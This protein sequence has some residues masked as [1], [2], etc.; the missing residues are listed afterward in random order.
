MKN[1]AKGGASKKEKRGDQHRFK[2][3][4]GKR[5]HNREEGEE[6]DREAEEAN[7]ERAELYKQAEDK[8]FEAFSSSSE[9]EPSDQEA[10]GEEEEQVS[11]NE[12]SPE[13]QIEGE[14]FG[15]LLKDLRLYD[16]RL[17]KLRLL[18]SSPS[19][20]ERGKEFVQEYHNLA[21]VYC[22]Y[23]MFYMQLASQK[24][25][26]VHPILRILSNLRPKVKEMDKEYARH[27]TE[28]TNLIEEVENRDL[29]EEDNEEP[30]EGEGDSEQEDE[31]D[32]GMNQ[33]ALHE[34]VRLPSTHKAT[35]PAKHTSNRKGLIHKKVQV[36]KL[37]APKSYSDIHQ[38]ISFGEDDQDD[39]LLNLNG[40]HSNQVP[41]AGEITMADFRAYQG[42]LADQ[43]PSKKASK[44]GKELYKEIENSKN[45]TK[46]L[47]NA[48]REESERAL[49][50]YE[51]K[52]M[53]NERKVKA[54][55]P[56]KLTEDM[57]LN[58]GLRA[59]RK[60][61]I[62]KVKIR[63]KFEKARHQDRIKKGLSLYD[64]KSGDIHMIRGTGDGVNRA[65]A[66]N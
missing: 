5:R 13:F 50:E 25:I 33:E 2:K 41:D 1:K 31:S 55:Q 30:V 45:Q 8:H 48:I 24:G 49:D 17:A 42:S 47:S 26:K 12:N 65:I 7:Q 18:M 43:K 54:D 23:L 16:L 19:L 20:T 37:E 14:F 58:R 38:Y 4:E 36:F 11:D 44:K 29:A 46:S 61:E 59:K 66:L 56:R 9:A 39:D 10:Q 64:H 34:A 51:R 3:G 62:S 21:S 15:T 53:F 63:R 60:N 28:A 32:N 35:K 57:M 22:L 52:L 27:K 6:S 40:R